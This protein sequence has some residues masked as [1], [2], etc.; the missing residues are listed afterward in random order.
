MERYAPPEHRRN[1]DVDCLRCG[2]R[3]IPE[4]KVCG[5]C[6]ASLPLVYDSEGKVFDPR[7]LSQR[8][9]AVQKGSRP[10]MSPQ[11]TG[12]I[13]RMGVILFAILMAIW[14]MHR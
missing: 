5:H 9:E 2:V 7:D 12:W 1:Y 6:G 14:I 4:N 10:R 13:L 3:N 8:W 11:A